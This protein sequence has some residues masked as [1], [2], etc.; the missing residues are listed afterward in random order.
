[1]AND[2]ATERVTSALA[3]LRNELSEMRN[4]DVQLMK[5]LLNINNSIQQLSKKNK[6]TKRVRV[7]HR[8]RRPLLSDAF[9]TA[10]LTKIDEDVSSSSS[11]S[12]GDNDECADKGLFRTN[13]KLW[14]YSQS[15]DSDSD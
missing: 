11:D 8:G 15:S 1:M 14:K 4:Q 12:E 10:E 13:V 2:N 6:S 9:K 3:V 5:Q 7:S